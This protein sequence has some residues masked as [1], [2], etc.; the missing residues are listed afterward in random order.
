MFFHCFLINIRYVDRFLWYVCGAE[1]DPGGVFL[2]VLFDIY[3]VFRFFFPLHFILSVPVCK[4]TDGIKKHIKIFELPQKISQRSH[5][6]TPSAQLTLISTAFCC[7]NG[8]AKQGLH[9]RWYIYIKWNLYRYQRNPA[10]INKTLIILFTLFDIGSSTETP[11]SG[12]WWRG[13]CEAEDLDP[14]PQS[15]SDPNQTSKCFFRGRCVV[16]TLD[17]FRFRPC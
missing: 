7:V 4:Y 15:G 10:V 17:M 1:W 11:R 3:S 14:D 6:K 13:I 9:E 16:L 8:S 12:L 2:F 5:I